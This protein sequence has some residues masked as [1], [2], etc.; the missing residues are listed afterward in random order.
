MSLANEIKSVDISTIMHFIFQNF[1][2]HVTFSNAYISLVHQWKIRFLIIVSKSIA[3]VVNCFLMTPLWRPL[4]KYGLGFFLP[5]FDRRK[6]YFFL[7]FFIWLERKY[8]Y[9]YRFLFHGRIYF[10]PVLKMTPEKKYIFLPVFR[11]H[12]GKLR[13]ENRWC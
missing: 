10:L 1:L 9:F 6:K 13:V 11:K 7:S 5:F 3:Q 4:S 2:D 12:R 8:F